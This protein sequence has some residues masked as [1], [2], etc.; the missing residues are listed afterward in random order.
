MIEFKSVPSADTQ[1]GFRFWFL[2]L[3]LVLMV[4]LGRSAS[5]QDPLEDKRMA[6]ILEIAATLPDPSKDA[7]ALTQEAAQ[8]CG[9][10]VWDESKNVVAEPVGKPRYGLGITTAEIKAFASMYRSG[11][12][13][14]LGD[15][16][17]G[18]DVLFHDAGGQGNLL[19]MIQPWLQLGSIREDPS[20]R[21]LSAFLLG[22]AGN[23]DESSDGNFTGDSSIDP[24]QALFIARVVS[25]DMA[26]PIRQQAAKLAPQ[27]ISENFTLASQP[28]FELPGWAEDAYTGTVNAV[29]DAMTAVKFESFNKAAGKFNAM[30]S[31]VKFISTYVFLGSELKVEEPG[32]PLV[33]TKDTSPGERRTLVARFFIDGSKVTDWLKDNR[34]IIALAGLDADMPKSGPIGGVETGWEFGQSTKYNSKQ[35][36]QYVGQVDISKVKTDDSGVA[37]VIVEGKPQPQKLDPN[38]VRPTMKKVQ[39][40][41][42]PQVKSTEIKQDW[43]D[44]VLGAAGIRNGPGIGFLTPVIECLYRMKWAG[45]KVMDLQ[46]KDWVAAEAIGQISIEVEGKGTFFSKELNL[47]QSMS[48]RLEISDAVMEQRGGDVNKMPEI[49][50][51]VLAKLPPEQRKAYEESIKQL[52]QLRSKLSFTITSP[53]TVAYLVND[54]TTRSGLTGE[55]IVASFDARETWNAQANYIEPNKPPKTYIQVQI[56]VDKDA[57]K[58]SMAIVANAFGK[59]E[60]YFHESDKP[61]VNRSEEKLIGIF[62]RCDDLPDNWVVD[63]KTTL[64]TDGDREDYYG[65]GSY[66]Y[67]FGKFTGVIRIAFSITRKIKK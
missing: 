29:V 43:V 19:P 44:A 33:R 22:L 34:K 39:I 25:E 37:K 50:E 46:I 30:A 32:Q 16:V 13:V 31:I 26:M 58:A 7:V 52:K 21:A 47:V 5:A 55:C 6:R 3:A 9:F 48:H 67:K 23:H 8:L 2:L 40:R 56:D 36:I 65:V 4:L 63:L 15:F 1:R 61:A 11:H 24:I 54:R 51:S 45:A 20:R 53:A 12:S 10:V 64:S 41:V 38:K 35:L 14:K 60:S 66:P 59:Y 28:K 27:A 18:L 57:K 17:A 62:D 42:T 49:P